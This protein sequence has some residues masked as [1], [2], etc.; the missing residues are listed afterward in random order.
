MA[1]ACPDLRTVQTCMVR[2]GL[3]LTSCPE[4]MAIRFCVNIRHLISVYFGTSIVRVQFYGRAQNLSCL[5]QEGPCCQV[6]NN[7]QNP[8]SKQTGGVSGSLDS[9]PVGGDLGSSPGR[10]PRA[11]Q[12]TLWVSE[13]GQGRE[14]RKEGPGQF[15]E[16]EECFVIITRGY[17]FY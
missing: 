1:D 17:V 4:D 10:W 12:A 5:M 14:A 8:H 7:S 11:L 9:S 13:P 15:P 2:V 16:Q 3:L 6:R